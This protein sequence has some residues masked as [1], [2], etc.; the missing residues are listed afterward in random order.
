MRVSTYRQLEQE[1][2]NAVK[3]ASYR[4]TVRAVRYAKGISAG[5]FSTKELA[6][7]DHPYAKR[8]GRI[9]SWVHPF[10]INKQTGNFQKGWKAVHVNVITN[11]VFY[12]SNL[13]YGTKLFF[14][15]PFIE[16]IRKT[17]KRLR[18]EEIERELALLG[19]PARSSRGRE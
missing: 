17:W 6:E 12:A 15:R 14:G 2:K 11:P 19:M 7:G 1:I 18:K 5:P 10:W 8:H 13:A 4:S 16:M 3:R 9:L